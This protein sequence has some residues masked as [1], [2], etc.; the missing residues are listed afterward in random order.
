MLMTFNFWHAKT[1]Q[2]QLEFLTL[3]IYW[4]AGI[5]CNSIINVVGNLKTTEAN[6]RK[7]F[8]AGKQNAMQAKN[9][10]AFHCAKI[11]RLAVL[12]NEHDG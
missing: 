11:Q 7:A 9:T 4:K 5:V 8:H 1:P 6:S 3:A 12:A 10:T 2:V